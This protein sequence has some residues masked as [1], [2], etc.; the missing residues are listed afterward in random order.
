MIE[1]ARLLLREY[2]LEDMPDLHSIQ[3]HAVTMKFWASPFTEENTRNWIERA[4]GS[5]STNGFGRYAAIHKGTNT[6]IGDVGMMR[7][8]VKG[9]E[10]VDLGYIIHADHWRKGYAIEAASAV[11]RFGTEK[12]LP[13]IVA[14]MAHDNIASQRVAERLGMIKELEF[15]NPRNR[16]ILTYLFVFNTP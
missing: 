7:S 4:I 16:D 12:K 1:T 11:L 6:Q 13:R 10:E 2:T 9:K 14:N 8:P 3:S 15:I 5:Y